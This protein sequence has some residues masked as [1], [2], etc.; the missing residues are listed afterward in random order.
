MLAAHIFQG[1]HARALRGTPAATD[2]RYSVEELRSVLARCR[3]VV[4]NISLEPQDLATLREAAPNAEVYCSWNAHAY[5]TQDY[6]N[7]AMKDLREKLHRWIAS[8]ALPEYR[9]GLEA[10]ENVVAEVEA[11]T[12]ARGFDGTYFDELWLRLPQ[13]VAAKWAGAMSPTLAAQRWLR[14]RD[15]FMSRVSTRMLANI[16]GVIGAANAFSPAPVSI[17]ENHGDIRSIVRELVKIDDERCTIFPRMDWTG[18]DQTGFLYASAPEIE[19][20]VCRG[21]GLPQG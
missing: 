8:D 4:A 21:V 2:P 17:E 13:W 10:V 11:V 18:K 20:L 19:G 3:V 6:G 15:H 9:M 16:G 1:H 7:A 12:K 5:P 14:C